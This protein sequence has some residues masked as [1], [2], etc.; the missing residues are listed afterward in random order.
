M[1]CEGKDGLT[2][3]SHPRLRV[4]TPVRRAIEIL[5]ENYPR[6]PQNAE[7]EGASARFPMEHTRDADEAFHLMQQADGELSGQARNSWRWRILYLR[8]VI[9]SELAGNDFKVSPRCEKASEE[10]SKIYYAQK[11]PF[12]EAPPTIQSIDKLRKTKNPLG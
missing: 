10:L 6:K 7:K 2:R 5:E 8:A 1:R 11:A 4:T 3:F 9:D 12:S